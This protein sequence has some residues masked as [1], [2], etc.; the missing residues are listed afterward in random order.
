MHNLARP[1]PVSRKM[2]M[3]FQAAM[4]QGF[5]SVF[6]FFLLKDLWKPNCLMTDMQ[7]GCLNRENAKRQ[8]LWCFYLH[9]HISLISK[10]SPS[11]LQSKES[12][13]SNWGTMTEK[14]LYRS[15]DIYINHFFQLRISICYPPQT[16]SASQ[17]NEYIDYPNMAIASLHLDLVYF[18][19]M[20]IICYHKYNR[21]M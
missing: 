17:I 11:Q 20:S 16:L 2:D 3:S 13:R 4:L 18:C 1:S 14:T 21:V 15:H 7:E 6:F 8:K 10:P 12:R 5:F 19:N 9:C